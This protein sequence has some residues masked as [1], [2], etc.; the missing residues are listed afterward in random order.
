[1]SKHDN[2][3]SILNKLNSLE[4]QPAKEPSLLK[5]LNES[6]HVFN[7]LS[8]KDRLTERYLAEKKMPKEVDE[9][10]LAKKDY[11]GDGRRES[12]KAEYMGSRD[13]AIKKAMGKKTVVDEGE[14][15]DTVDKSKI[16][17]FQRKAK[18]APGDDSW[19]VSQ[20][21]LDDEA[22]KSPTGSAGL[23]KAKQRLGMNEIGR[24]HV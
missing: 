21:D 17:A 4:P 9:D 24:A 12:G 10:M 1:M 7:P 15:Q 22:S 14:Y 2:I 5:Q 11:D 16:P 18:A 20:Q 8:L 19:K 3:Y 13:K 6:V 23:A